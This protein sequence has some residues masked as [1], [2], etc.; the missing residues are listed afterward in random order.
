MQV[1]CRH[2]EWETPGGNQIRI[3]VVS[4]RLDDSLER[5]S[6]PPYSLPR[7]SRLSL[8]PRSKGAEEL[9]PGNLG[10]VEPLPLG[11][12]GKLLWPQDF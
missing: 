3:A 6:L 10:V 9:V 8:A 11:L 1:R 5:F 12:P 2:W 4:L 7:V